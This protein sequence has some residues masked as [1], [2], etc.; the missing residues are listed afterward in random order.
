MPSSLVYAA[1]I[2]TGITVLIGTLVILPAFVNDE[3]HQILLSFE[4]QPHG[5]ITEFCNELADLL[6]KEQTQ[7]TLFISGILAE[8]HPSCITKFGTNT[9]IGSQTYSY[10]ELPT[11]YDYLEQQK[12]IEL[13]KKTIDD[14]GN[15]DS[16]L[17]KAPNM[18]T[19][20]NIY[21]LLDRNGIEFDLSY[22]DHYNKYH[23]NQFLRFELTSLNWDEI[24]STNFSALDKDIPILITLDSSVS[25][26]NIDQVIQQLKTKNVKF[27]NPS[28]LMNK[29]L[30]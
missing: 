29:N 16:K 30:N 11:I 22:S 6:N 28:N 13:G 8:E 12:E 10:K 20:D 26:Y 27:I 4:I 3:K 17:F 18:N 25:I 5:N 7:S 15:I 21:S 1:S 9:D 14:I 23:E 19:D 2:A 24:Q